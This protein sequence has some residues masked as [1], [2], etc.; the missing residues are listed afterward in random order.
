LR[1][2]LQ[3]GRLCL[4]ELIARE[5]HLADFLGFDQ[6]QK[7]AVIN[8][9]VAAEF[10]NHPR[11]HDGHRENDQPK[12]AAW[13]SRPGATARRTAWRWGLARRHANSSK[14]RPKKPEDAP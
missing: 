12:P 5:D 9:A 13:R 6:F 10:L 7:V 2:L 4:D 1:R 14:A 3:V 11:H 8:I